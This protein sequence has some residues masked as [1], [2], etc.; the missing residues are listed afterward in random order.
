MVTKL[1]WFASCSPCF[2][3][4]RAVAGGVNRERVLK[5]PENYEIE[6]RYQKLHCKTKLLTKSHV[7]ILSKMVSTHLWNTPPLPIGQWYWCI[8][9]CEVGGIFCREW[10]RKCGIIPTH[11]SYSTR[12]E[13]K[14]SNTTYMF[15]Q[16]KHVSFC[17][18]EPKAVFESEALRMEAL[19]K[20][21]IPMVALGL[22]DTWTS[23]D[24]LD[25][26]VDGQNP[27]P[28]DM[29]LKGIPSVKLTAI[30]PEKLMVGRWS[31]PLPF[32][33][34][35]LSC[36]AV[37]VLWVSRRAI[38]SCVQICVVYGFVTSRGSAK[39]WE[40]LLWISGTSWGSTSF[41]ILVADGDVAQLFVLERNQTVFF[42]IGTHLPKHRS[43]P[44]LT[45]KF[46]A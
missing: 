3:G 19:Q 40:S 22:S 6:M 15:I 33:A 10:C 28:V 1:F 42:L 5:H 44:H 23:R 26:N 14:L 11:T 4:A 27:A 17:P 39:G 20:L 38:S 8:V 7:E 43:W 36:G 9:V 12:I 16:H 18:Y 2:D 37:A 46:A 41:S 35:D 25:Q 45:V 30:A 21:D 34:I 24:S 29:F 13:L 31:F 32:G